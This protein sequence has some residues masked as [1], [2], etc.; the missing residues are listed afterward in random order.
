[1]KNK[2][3]GKIIKATALV[4]D[5][6]SPLVATMTQFPVWIQHSSEST[7]SG[8]FLLFTMLSAIPF[9]KQIKEWVKSP[10]A[11]VMWCIMLVVFILLRNI[12][13]QMVIICFVGAVA[14]ILGSGI[15]KF[16]IHIEGKEDKL[17]EYV[18]ETD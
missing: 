15:Y 17:K 6:G 3:K 2:T 16:G 13:D 7:I 5:V 14:N 1:M 11:W 9:M 12:I 4:L 10:S 8:V 18:D